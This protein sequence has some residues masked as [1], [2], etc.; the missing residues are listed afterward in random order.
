MLLFVSRVKTC[1]GS[2][3]K[4][5]TE[6][7]LFVFNDVMTENIDLA[8]VKQSEGIYVNVLGISPGGLD[9]REVV[10]SHMIFGDRAKSKYVVGPLKGFS[11]VDVQPS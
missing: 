4:D 2:F 7:C 3:Q 1:D 8:V 6:K 9:V 5:S 11:S 10:S